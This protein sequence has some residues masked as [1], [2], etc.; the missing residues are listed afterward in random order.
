MF[1]FKENKKN[2]ENNKIFLPTRSIYA[3]TF[4]KNTNGNDVIA[5]ISGK[6]KHVR[7]HQLPSLEGPDSEVIKIDET[8]GS[9]MIT[10]GAAFTSRSRA[11]MVEI[12]ENGGGE[13]FELAKN[14]LAMA[15][16]WALAVMLQKTK[17]FLY[18]ISFKTVAKGPTRT[19][20]SQN[21][22]V[23]VINRIESPYPVTSMQIHD[24]RLILG[25]QASFC[26][27]LWGGENLFF[28]FT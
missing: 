18:D 2:Y 22:E 11:E 21:V 20:I 15:K 27:Y 25:H 19:D 16:K 1:F 3:V 13:T 28:Y 17:V 5:V 23:K 4:M 26:L 7:L 14:Q 24:G 10:S 8:R 9:M 12:A 6:Q